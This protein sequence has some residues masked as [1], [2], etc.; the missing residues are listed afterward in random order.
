MGIRNTETG[1]GWP[2]RLL[3]WGIAIA[4][5]GQ[6]SVG[7]YMVNV[8]EGTADRMLARNQL[9]QIH[10]S[11]GTVVFALV[12]LRVV[13]R[14]ANPVPVPPAG[15]GR[16]QRHL[17]EGVHLALYVLMLALPLSGWLMAT[18]SPLNDPDNYP[19]QIR[20]MVFGLFALPDPYPEGDRAVTAFWASVHA[21]AAGAMAVLF[22]LHVAGALKHHLVDR[23][24]VLRRMVAGA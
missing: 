3:H 5:L 6:L 7:F 18:S 13:W 21:W 16:A 17:S 19:V 15:M 1:W 8:L 11:W 12:V 4:I 23:D 14:L 10:R 24:G 20:N 2:H 22:A 9:P